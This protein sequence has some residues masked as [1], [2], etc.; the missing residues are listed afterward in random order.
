MHQSYAIV[1]FGSV[2]KTEH[3]ATVTVSN[4]SVQLTSQI[5]ASV[6]AVA[7]ADHSSDEVMI[8]DIIVSAG[9]IVAGVSFDINAYCS[10]GTYG[11]YQVNYLITY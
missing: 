5:I 9:N 4:S 3:N 11:Q 7:T 10:G 8:E 6:A 1:T 2:N